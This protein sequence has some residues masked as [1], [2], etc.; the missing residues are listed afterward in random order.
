VNDIPGLGMSPEA[1]LRDDRIAIFEAYQRD[2]LVASCMSGQ[3]F[4]WEPE[5]LYPEQSLLDVAT[6]MQVRPTSPADGKAAAERNGALERALSIADRD[7][8]SRA[9]YGYSVEELDARREKGDD[10]VGAGGCLSFATGGPRIWDVREAYIS[11]WTGLLSAAR[12]DPATGET[13]AV[14]ADCYCDHGAPGVDLGEPGAL[15]QFVGDGGDPRVFEAAIGACRD[16]QV[17]ADRIRQQVAS[18]EFVA[19]YGGEL[20]PQVRRYQQ[21]IPTI[22]TDVQFRLVLSMRAGEAL[23]VLGR[24]EGGH[25]DEGGG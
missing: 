24:D 6:D 3:G 1:V 25:A 16:V 10:L 11:R 22:E 13:Q 20:S 15:D 7:R 17:A 2:S 14:V 19:R 23:A 5:V 9:L 21:M 4:T 18:D 12:Q 8:Y